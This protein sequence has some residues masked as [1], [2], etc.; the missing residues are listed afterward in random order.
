MKAKDLRLLDRIEGKFSQSLALIGAITGLSSAALDE[1][2]T[3]DVEGIGTL[4]G[5][6]FPGRQATGDTALAT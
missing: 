1:M 5:D 2:D 6:F 3:E 4:I